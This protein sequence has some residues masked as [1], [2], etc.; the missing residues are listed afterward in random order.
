MSALRKPWL[1]AVLS[2]V[3]TGLGQVYCGRFVRGLRL[4]LSTLVV[5]PVALGVALLPPSQAL[6]IAF[7][8]VCVTPLLVKAYAVLDAWRIAR[9]LGEGSAPQPY[10]HPVVYAAFAVGSVGLAFAVALAIRAWVFE[11]FFI[12]QGSMK[13]TLVPGDR[14]LGNKLRV[15]MGAVSRGDIVVYHSRDHGGRDMLVVQRVIGLP[16]DQVQVRQ[17][18]V[19]VNGEPLRVESDGSDGDTKRESIGERSYRIVAGGHPGRDLP[20][21]RLGDGEYYVLGDYRTAAKDSRVV[22][23]IARRDLVCTVEYRYESAEEWSRIGALDD[24]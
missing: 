17:G 16:G 23:P 21:L 7:A 22:G 10:Q 11:A 9:R 8:A 2:L 1:A 6:W 15:G 12:P 13:P 20:E 14:V 3:C 5:A 4:Q 24:E 19:I 18:Q